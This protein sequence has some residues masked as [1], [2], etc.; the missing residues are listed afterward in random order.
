MILNFTRPAHEDL[1]GIK[2]INF[3]QELNPSR[4]PETR[5]SNHI[6]YRVKPALFESLI[7]V[8]K[9]SYKNFPYFKIERLF[10]SIPI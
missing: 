8:Q 9:N 5:F 10:K 3:S 2:E 4:S 6:R 7:F 1:F